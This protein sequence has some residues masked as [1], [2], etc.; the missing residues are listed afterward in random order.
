MSHEINDKET[1]RKYSNL[2]KSHTI[3]ALNGCVH[4]LNEVVE[5]TLSNGD[6]LHVYKCTKCE[7]LFLDREIK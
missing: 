2:H 5:G 7:L 1:V 3:P 6:H 4:N